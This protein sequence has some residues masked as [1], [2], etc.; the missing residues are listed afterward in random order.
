MHH[1]QAVKIEFLKLFLIC[2]LQFGGDD[3]HTYLSE[4]CQYS[5]LNLMEVPKKLCVH[6]HFYHSPSHR[7]KEVGGKVK[8][9]GCHTSMFL[10]H[11]PYTAATATASPPHLPEVVPF[12]RCKFSNYLIPNRWRSSFF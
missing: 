11:F 9:G 5:F 7:G 3:N 6:F 1:L 4:T 10:K 8:M 2:F 12:P